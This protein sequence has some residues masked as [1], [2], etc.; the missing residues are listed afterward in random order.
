[1]VSMAGL[2]WIQDGTRSTVSLDGP[3]GVGGVRIVDDAG[4]A[5]AD[6]PVR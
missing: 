3:L 2:R 1:M 4:V 5:D 6:E